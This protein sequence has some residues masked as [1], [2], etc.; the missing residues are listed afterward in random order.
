MEPR[1]GCWLAG[2]TFIVG[3]LVLGVVGVYWILPATSREAQKTARVAAAREGPFGLEAGMPLADVREISGATAVGKGSGEFRL[4]DVPKPHSDFA[5]YRVF[6]TERVG[7]C[8]I[9]ALGRPFTTDSDGERTR[10]RFEALAA[11]LSSLYGDGLKVDRV[12]EGSIWTT[13][14]SFTIGLMKGE[15]TLMMVWSEPELTLPHELATI[16]LVTE[17]LGVNEV[18]FTLGYQFDNYKACEEEI[19]ASERDAL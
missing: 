14:G 7:L 10:S 3:G 16:G 18:R 8:S 5:E 17:A 9:L 12:T 11:E 2:L 1:H 15:R 4:T 6:A 19:K 13:P